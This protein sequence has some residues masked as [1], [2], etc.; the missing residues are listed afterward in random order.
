LADC[1]ALVLVRPFAQLLA[2]AML[3]GCVRIGFDAR[4]V[5]H[6]RYVCGLDVVL[7][8]LDGNP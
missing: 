8:K 3:G 2:L 7:M 6:Q 5:D 1:D 4:D